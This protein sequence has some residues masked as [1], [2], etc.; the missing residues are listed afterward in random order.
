MNAS[1]LESSPYLIFFLFEFLAAAALVFEKMDSGR[2]NFALAGRQE[3]KA[4]LHG[5]PAISDIHRSRGIVWVTTSL[6]RIPALISFAI[7]W[8]ENCCDARRDGHRI[9]QILWTGEMPCMDPQL[10]MER[11][12]DAIPRLGVRQS[13]QHR[14]VSGGHQEQERYGQRILTRV[15]LVT[16]RH[17]G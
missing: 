4:A 12:S 13:L 9:P 11:N 5:W 10:E 3:T 6:R 1:T 17:A 14:Q 8:M 15:S 7:G 2:S 16:P